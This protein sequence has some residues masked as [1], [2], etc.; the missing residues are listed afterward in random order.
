ML[1]H[2]NAAGPKIDRA[3]TSSVSEV[4]IGWSAARLSSFW[5]TRRTLSIAVTSLLP[6]HDNP[7]RGHPGHAL[8]GKLH[9]EPIGALTN[10]LQLGAVRNL[11][12]N[13]RGNGRPAARIR[14]V[15]RHDGNVLGHSSYQRH[16]NSVL[17][18]LGRF[19]DRGCPEIR[20]F[21]IRGQLDLP[22]HRRAGARRQV[23]PQS[24][25]VRQFSRVE[26]RRTHSDTNF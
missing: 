25:P 13:A 15:T 16:A 18:N 23:G 5:P 1:A 22:G 9:F 24:P 12:D 14:G 7:A 17:D 21:E 2:V 10:D 8:I 6:R 26:T 4:S 3:V 19:L 11:I 20:G